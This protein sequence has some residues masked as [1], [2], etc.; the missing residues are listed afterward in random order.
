LAERKDT[1]ISN[2]LDASSDVGLNGVVRVSTFNFDVD[3]GL[4]PMSDRFRDYALSEGCDS[5]TRQE[6]NT[7]KQTGTGIVAQD[8]TQQLTRQGTIASNTAP[9]R[10]SEPKSVALIPAQGWEK[11]PDGKVKFIAASWP[12]AGSGEGMKTCLDRGS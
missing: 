3:R 7:L 11:T 1:I 6:L 5:R 4:Q 10:A 12:Y 2:D 8:L 9:T